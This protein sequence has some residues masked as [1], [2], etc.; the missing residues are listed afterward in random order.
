MKYLLLLLFVCLCG[1]DFDS[2]LPGKKFCWK[3]IPYAVGECKSMYCR[4]VRLDEYLSNNFEQLIEPGT[5][6]VLIQ[7]ADKECP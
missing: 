2:D 3:G 6:R 1:C 7:H 4:V 5:V